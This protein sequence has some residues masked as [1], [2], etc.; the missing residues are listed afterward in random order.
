IINGNYRGPLHGVPI[1]LKDN[2]FTKN[3]QTTMGSG[4]FKEYLPSYDATVVKKL[5]AAGSVFLGKLNMHEFAYG[6]TGDRSY[7]GPVKNSYAH[8]KISGGSSSGS[9]TA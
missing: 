8:S 7:F 3:I 2:I 1:A 5:A 6:T 4:I 9:G